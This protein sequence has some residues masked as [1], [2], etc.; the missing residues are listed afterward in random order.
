MKEKKDELEDNSF[1]VSNSTTESE[2]DFEV[3]AAKNVEKKSASYEADLDEDEAEQRSNKKPAWA[4]AGLTLLGLGLAFVAWLFWQPAKVDAQSEPETQSAPALPEKVHYRLG[5]QPNTYAAKGA[6]RATEQ[7]RFTELNDATVKMMDEKNVADV[8]LEGAKIKDGD[9][10]KLAGLKNIYMLDLQDGTGFSHKGLKAFKNT[11]LKRL[12]L[13]GSGVTDDWIP[14]IIE[15]PVEFLSLM[16]NKLSDES[17]EK[18]ANSATLK[19][20]KFEADNSKK[21]ID[22]FRSGQWLRLPEGNT[23]AFS[24]YR[25]ANPPPQQQ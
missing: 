13:D 25:N 19:Y 20:L 17:I 4:L 8:S 18:L 9:L 12:Y 3:R 16:G 14:T 24:F 21:L 11:N 23:R 1:V 10:K 7:N 2:Q 6:L 22:T 5:L 15:L